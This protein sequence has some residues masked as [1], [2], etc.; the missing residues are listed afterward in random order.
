MI[1]KLNKNPQDKA[2]VIKAEKKL[3]DNGFVAYV[4]D[5][6][7]EIQEFLR[8]TDVQNFLPWR[9]VFKSSSITTPCRPVFDASMPTA[10]GFSLND[11]LAKGRN[12]MN[13]MVEIFIRWRSH[14][15]AYHN[16][17]NTM[18]NQVKLEHSY[19]SMQR[20]WWHETLDPDEPP[21]EKVIK[22]LIYGCKSSGN[23]AEHAIRL[24]ASLFKED[25]PEI[26]EIVHKD[27]Y[28]DDCMSGESSLD[29]CVSSH[30]IVD[31]RTGDLELI[32]N[33]G[34]FTLK[35][36]TVSGRPPDASVTKDG[37]SIGVAGHRWF[38]EEDAIGLDVSEPNFATKKRGKFEG[39]MK[40]VPKKLK[41]VTCGSKVAEI[42]DLSGLLTPITATFKVDL[43]GMV[44][45]KLDWQDVL[46]DNLRSLWIS[47]FELMSEIK[48]IKYNRAV[49]PSDAVSLDVTTLDFGDASKDLACVAIY[50]RYRRKCGTYSCQLIFARSKLI[51]DGMT[52]P[53]AELFAALIN[54]HTGEVVRKAL[55]KH[56]RGASKFTDSQ[57]TLFWISRDSRTMKT[58]LRNRVVDIRMFTLIS[59]WRY[60]KSKDMIADLGTR[61]CTSI[62]AVDQNSD[63]I[64]GFPWMSED[65]SSFP[66]LTVEEIALSTK[67][68]E[69]ASK[70]IQID[71]NIH[72]RLFYTDSEAVSTR[73]LLKARYLYSDYLIDPNYRSH[74]EV[75]RILAIIY[76]FIRTL[77]HEVSRSRSGVVKIK[78]SSK[79]SEGL[80]FIS[81]DSLVE[82][83]KYYFRKATNE[84]KHYLKPSQYQNISKEIEGI[85]YYTG[86]ILPSDEV[87]IVG[88]A[89]E[90][91]RDLSST[92]FCVPLTDRYSPIAYSVINDVHW[93][94][95]TACHTGVETTWRYVLKHV[96]VIE[97]RPLVRKFRESCQRCRFLAKKA[98]AVS[99]GPI[100]N[101]NIRVA[102]AYYVCQADLVG[103]FSAYSY[104]NKRTT[105]KIWLIVFCCSTTSATNIKV[106]ESYNTSSFL[107]AFM[108]FC[109][110]VGYPKRVLV[111]KGSQ[112]VQGC[113]S[114]RLDI[115][116]LKFHLHK[117][118]SVELSVC[119]V[120]GHNMHGKVERRIRQ[121]RESLSKAL[122]NQRL[123]ILQWET[124]SATIANSI[125][126]LPLTLGSKKADLD[127]MD[128]ITPNRLLLGRN[129]DRCP[130][131]T[132]STTPQHDKLIAENEQIFNSWFENWLVSHVPK[133]MTQPKW[134]NSD[135]DLKEGDVVLFL[136][137]E[138][139][140]SSHYQ[141][142]I[143]EAVEVGRDGKVRK[144]SVRYRNHNESIN[145]TT[146][147]SARSLIVIHPSDETNI[148]QELGQIAMEVDR[149]RT[150]FSAQPQ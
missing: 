125:N 56:H 44:K 95:K 148:I 93:N 41:R 4:K 50:A 9:V 33:R 96:Y 68:T 85:L 101:D 61:R 113:E 134:F 70:E 62:H 46:P 34:G 69:E 58:W 42:F 124:L 5:L 8:S 138:S 91:M 120:G 100:S 14:M 11:L 82:A 75:I 45:R 73:E 118:A 103:S 146:F 30:S 7:E 84:I 89:T 107:Q 88:K 17:I 57:I 60:L 139:E 133:L 79:S 105:I 47:H 54:S 143:V 150:K 90:V 114:V 25:F 64:N 10:S 92:T 24:T 111:D 13:K 141:Y 39:E 147:R 67:E 20:Y 116:D 137:H 66:S 78:N 65:E 86:R 97:G 77:Q 32:L 108:R 48:N 122:S 104:H 37:V 51:P 74:N 106:M 40:E 26:N 3:H 123:G 43:H 16:D 18:Y 81:N 130:A 119:P 127:S 94:D 49:I 110:E 12:S 112:L 72:D 29:P 117:D 27:L 121:V 98:L 80:V 142:G 52:Q 2:S 144:V 21:V 102:P 128:L 38:S 126:N 145:R 109:C 99:M 129:N 136:K 31:E 53:R 76:T 135:R 115:Q 19:W 63:W 59:Q 1:K 15:T 55:Y 140:I 131:G 83:E 28:V 149:E 132:F 35:S 71:P 36:F 6:P 22:T 87:T 23:Q